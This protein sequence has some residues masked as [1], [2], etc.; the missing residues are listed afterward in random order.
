VSSN[1]FG[2]DG[3]LVA[4]PYIIVKRGGYSFGITGVTTPERLVAIDDS[5]IVKPPIA[6]IRDIWNELRSKS[7]FQIILSHLGEESSR[8][9]MD[10]FPECGLVVNGHR[11]SSTEEFIS[12]RGQILL[13][14]GFQGKALSFAE[15]TPDGKGLGIGRNGWLEVGPSIPDDSTAQKL[16]VLPSSVSANSKKVFDLYIMSQCRYGCAALKEFV[17]FAAGFP[18]VEWHVWF[19]GSVG[20]DNSL[21]SLHG[22][23]EVADEMLWLAVETLY[24]NRW[25]EFLTKRSA[26][27]DVA[28]E[29]II[30]SMKLDLSKI[31]KWADTKGKSELALQYVRSMRMGINASPTLLV[32]NGAFTEDIIRPRLARAMCGTAGVRSAYCDSIPECFDDHDCKK[33]GKV[34][35]CV[36][37]A[38]HKAVCEFDN[39][40]K[41]GMSMLL[42]DSAFS[43]P[44]SGVLMSLS[45]EFPGMVVDTVRIGTQR[46][47]SLATSFHPAFLPVFLFD[48]EIAKA[49]NFHEFEPSVVLS[50]DKYV[51]G[52]GMV[53]PTYFYKRAAKPG[54]ITLF[55]DPAFPGARDA[56][57]I[58]LGSTGKTA[59][60]VVLPV[61]YDPKDSAGTASET[62]I[63]NEESLRWLVLAEK[64]PAQYKL[65]LER[66]AERATMSY[67]FTDISKLG[68][69]VDDFVKV[70]E[71]SSAELGAHAAFIRELGIREPVEALINNREVVAVK[72]PGDLRDML[73]RLLK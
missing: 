41:F 10:S 39:A 70:V 46:G 36:S 2:Y 8:E 60:V 18:T 64:Y 5:V 47:M 42:P 56:M 65:Y 20:I 34:G 49:P 26:V 69:N 6:A 45:E 4:A 12:E 24:P 28:T 51:F 43:H 62:A 14:F 32:N 29:T 61:V 58:A 9:L 3:R 17:A 55:V 63:R 68:I 16:I 53:K 22:P 21:T 50:G 23:D 33:T 54:S 7:D 15:I 31:K 11:K 66:F 40:V 72:N 67:W 1:C 52:P 44:E 71:A 59:T 30:R 13:Q 73:S 57:R 25:L 38:G 35:H 27:A 37:R 48:K 19:I